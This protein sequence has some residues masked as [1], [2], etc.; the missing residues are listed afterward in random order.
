MPCT[1]VALVLAID[2]S[3]SIDEAEFA[4]QMQAT[5]RALVNPDVVQAMR[6]AGGVAVAAVI[7]GDSAWSA[8]VTD[9]HL[10]SG[11]DQATA[12]A[13]GLASLPRSVGGNTDLG[14]GVELALDLLDRQDNCASRLLIDVSGDGRETLYTRSRSI[15]LR[16]VRD[17]AEDMGVQING[18]AITVD[19][20]G[21]AEYYASRVILGDGAFVMTVTDWSSFPDAIVRKLLREIGEPPA[22]AEVQVGDGPAVPAPSGT[23]APNGSL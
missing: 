18:L 11:E 20:P 21:L 12:F 22:V 6:A 3:S 8:H 1:D 15:S 23:G 2:S 9:W 7:W 13:A 10:V 5:A 17:R 19:D 14:H 16:E 4:L